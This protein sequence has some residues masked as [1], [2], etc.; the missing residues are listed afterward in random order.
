MNPGCRLSYATNDRGFATLATEMNGFAATR[1]L[2]G[3]N[4]ARLVRC[5]ALA[6]ALA[7][8]AC[9]GLA[10]DDQ[11]QLQPQTV[12]GP[13]QVKKFFILSLTSVHTE[14]TVANA[15][16]ACT[17]TVFNPDLQIVLNAAYVTTQPSHGQAG[18]ALVQL[19]RQGS[20]SYTP[21]PGY[22]GRDEFAV[23]F[24]PQDLG[25]TVHVTVQPPG[26]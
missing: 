18:A 7:A 20:V 10:R 6:T 22:A 3:R 19:G 23:T 1:R 5:A 25:I 24:E 15:G 8:T 13:C 9:A 12:R 16:Q 26:R 21:Q 2:R 17:F 14:M 11:G 4:G